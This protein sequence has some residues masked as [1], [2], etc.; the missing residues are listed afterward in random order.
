[1]LTMER[2]ILEKRNVFEGMSVPRAVAAMAAPTV[3][4]QLVTLIYN[5]ADTFFVGRTNYPAL[6]AGVSLILP[7]FNVIIALANVAGTGGG[8]L[9][10]RLMGQGKGDRARRVAAFS[11]CASLAAGAVFS[12][13]TTAWMDGIL[14]LL[15]AG[16]ATFAA[17]KSYAR[18]VIT[19]GSVP[20]VLSLTMS[21]LLRST[22]HSRE[23]GLGVSMGGVLNILLD[24]LFMFVLLPPGKEPLGAGLAT[25]LS[26]VTVCLYYLI[27]IRRKGG[28]ILR[29]SLREVR[30]EGRYIR[31]FLA[32]GVPAAVGPL[33]FDLDCIVLNRLMAAYG[34]ETLAASGILLKVERL[35]LNV[36]I[37]MLLG[38][39]PL[40]AYSYSAGDKA[41]TEEIVRFT[42]RSV[43][44]ISLV[45]TVLYEALA[46]GVIRLFIAEPTTVALGAR[47]IRLRTPA[48]MVMLLSML[49]YYYFQAVGR[50]EYAFL[51][52]VIRW[53]AV[54]IPLL[55]L[56][57]APF[58]KYGLVCSQLI[59]DC[60]VSTVSW[61]IYR[62]FRKRADLP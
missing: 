43:I 38:M 10:T 12:L 23:A 45:T 32:V 48:A 31:Q 49:Y 41:R 3:I 19:A 42:R 59:G 8:T 15:G 5:M 55:F 40:A 33:L 11:V 44:L 6:V 21:S 60:V 7:L 28:P 27:V 57:N 1:M 61:G 9:I 56:L 25:V 36:G 18:C 46:P 37:G 17:A 54:N 2:N 4:G 51:L 29:F 26:N 16:P 35:P 47:F 20:V 50:G 52:V 13:I 24:P 58:G 53:A 22:G 30:L 62:R 34:D 14:T 39:V